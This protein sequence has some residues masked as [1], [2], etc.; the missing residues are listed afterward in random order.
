MKLPAAV[1]S[2]FKKQRKR[3]KIIL[4]IIVLILGL[5]VAGRVIGANAKPKYITSSVQKGDVV[6]IVSET[7]NVNTTGRADVYTTTTGIIEEIYV[8][9][10]QK[11]ERDDKLFKVKST[12]TDQ[13]KAAAFASYQAALVS[14]QQAENTLRDKRATLDKVLDDVKDH[15]DDETFEQKE[16]RTTA[17]V[18][19]DNA[20]DAVKSA[21]AQLNPAWLEYQATQDATIKSPTDGTVANLSTK[22]GDKVEVGTRATVVLTVANLVDYSLRLSLSEVDIPKVKVGQNAVITMDAIPENSFN[23]NVSHVD[24]VGTNNQGVVTFNIMVTI[25]NPNPQIRPGMT[26]NVDVEVDKVQGVLT[27][28]NSA[29]KPY[30]GGRAVRVVDPKTKEMVFIPVEVGLK[31]EVKTEIKK[32]VSENQ[33]IITSLPNDQIKRNSLF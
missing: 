16:S 22:I 23:G 28:P 30:K 18:A 13:E 9:N 19:A 27:V 4:S 12:S 14:L 24:S 26:A 6:E 29:I 31:G 3:N 20:V 15:D 25:Q 8:E 11:V 10:N 17:Q 7:G 2:W 1:F 5:A 32:G 21:K 33:E